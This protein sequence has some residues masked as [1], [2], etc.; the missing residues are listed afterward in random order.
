MKKLFF[1][2][3]VLALVASCGQDTVTVKGKIAED[4]AQPA[5]SGFADNIRTTVAFAESYVLMFH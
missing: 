3:F 4:P 5:G 2:L 1:S